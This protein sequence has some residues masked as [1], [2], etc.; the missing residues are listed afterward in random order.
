MKKPSDLQQ[1]REH[2]T[3][4]APLKVSDLYL[5]NESSSLKESLVKTKGSL[6]K[7]L[8]SSVLPSLVY[9]I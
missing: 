7:I 1:A 2:E 4:F 9:G 8:P 5:T 3:P 6:V